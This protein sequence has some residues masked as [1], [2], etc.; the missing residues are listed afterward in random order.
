[1]VLPYLVA[2]N[3]LLDQPRVAIQAD[4]GIAPAPHLRVL[5]GP[6]RPTGR[7]EV[8]RPKLWPPS[9]PVSQTLQPGLVLG[10]VPGCGRSRLFKMKEP[11]YDWK[12][13]QP[14]FHS[15]AKRGGG[16]EGWR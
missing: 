13:S 2:Q 9:G 12:A 11:K 1:M 8:G 16:D 5:P 14:E 10:T 15:S 7:A 4:P 3:G 6:Q